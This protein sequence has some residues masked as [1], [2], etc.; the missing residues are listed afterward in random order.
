MSDVIYEKHGHIAHIKLNRPERL[1]ALSRSLAKELA[2]IWIDFRDDS[3][4]WVAV[5]SGV[6]K[7]FCSGADIEGLQTKTWEFRQSLIFGDDSLSPN[8]YQ[9]WKPII[10]AVHRHV[11][12]GGMWLALECDIRIATPDAL[13]G[14]PEAKVN[15]PVMFTAFISRFLPPGIAAELLFRGNSIDANRAYEL[16][17]I[18]KIVEKEELMS[19]AVTWAEELCDNGPLSVKAMKEIFYR[20]RDMDHAG[21]LALTEHLVTPVFRSD[22]F[23]EA[24]KAFKEKRKPQWTLR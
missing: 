9:V 12:G 22:D 6:G 13:F 21:A 1:N 7:S 20:T 3:D 2:K 14:L 23:Q 24:K 5:L 11:Y 8:T 18:N 19:T 15:I 10:A 4:L 17:L 16:G